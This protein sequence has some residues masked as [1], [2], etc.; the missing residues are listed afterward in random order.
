MRRTEAGLIQV[1]GVVLAAGASRR[2]GE[3]KQLARVG[4]E[5]LL[6]RAVRVAREA[7]LS[8]VVVVLGAEA[9][10]VQ[11]VC[12][13]GGVEVVVNETWAEGMGSSLRCGVEAVLRLAGGEGDGGVVEGGLRG[14]V[15]TTCDMPGV[16]AEHLRAL[17][18]ADGACVASAYAGQVGVPAYFPAAEFGRL[19]AAAG[20]T[21]ARGML[22]GART[23][24]LEGGEMDVDTPEGLRRARAALGR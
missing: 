23:I 12:A 3:M 20:D 15:V 11:E 2:L 1:A 8:P 6:E 21:G 14:V 10:R 7:D 9:A 24:A 18:A 16:G 5:R 4:G 22:A 19:L 13:L 17:A